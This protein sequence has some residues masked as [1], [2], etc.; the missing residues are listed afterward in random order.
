[1]TQA[2]LHVKTGDVVEVIAG[3]N[4]GSTGKVLVVNPKT[5]RALVE[6]LNL[7][8]KHIRPTNDNSEG[9]IVESEAP[10]HLSNLKVVEAAPKKEAK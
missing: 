8:K 5:S 9:G 7:M 2:K 1:M 3:K 4:R 10:L 6:G